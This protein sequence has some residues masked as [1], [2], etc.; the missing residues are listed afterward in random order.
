MV[1]NDLWTLAD[2]KDADATL[3]PHIRQRIRARARYEAANN[4]QVDRIL[5]VW[6]DDVVAATGPWP[7]LSTGNSQVDRFI[8]SAWLRWWSAS[9]QAAKM[10]LAVKAEA[11]D[12]ESIGI[13]FHSHRIL[14]DQRPLTAVSVD[15]A[16]FEADRLADPN[17]SGSNRS[18]YIDGIHLDPLTR[19]PIAY[20]LLKAHPGT[21]YLDQVTE[22][23]EAETFSRREFLH[24]FRKNRAE[25]HRGNCR[26]TAALPIAGLFRKYAEAEVDRM[27]T[28]AAFTVLFKSNVPGDDGTA[29]A[30]G[31]GNEDQW[32]QEVLLPA[33]K[34]VSSIL[35]EG[36]DPVQLKNDGQAADLRECR[37]IIA[38]LVAGC[39]SMPLGRAIGHSSSGGYPGQRADLLP[40]HKTIASD[41]LQVWEP[42]Y[43]R[44]LFK[45][46]LRELKSTEGWKILLAQLR[47]A[48]P[49]F[50]EWI[51]DLLNIEFR[52]PDRDLVVDPSREDEARRQ[53]RRKPD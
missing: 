27:A 43:L 21:E 41:R 34:G 33:R 29:E 12:G 45:E 48:D 6:A 4:P 19:E 50:S 35:P 36:F 18:D 37:D 40:Y 16:G 15:V 39:F 24:A 53:R 11:V 49:A 8:E 28:I 20:D 47:A 9:N 26:F 17:Y 22:I 13:I 7:K 46:F 1:R 44:R 51:L 38:G 32:W 2:F 25:Q 52:W 31:A 3:L 14:E 30:G 5:N 23:Y 10:K 42:L